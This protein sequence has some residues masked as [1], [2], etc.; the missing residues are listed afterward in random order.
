MALRRWILIATAVVAFGGSYALKRA[1]A[2]RREAPSAPSGGALRIVSL[3][4][5]LTEVAFELGLG[6]RLVGVTSFCVYPPEARTKPQMG[7]YYDPNYEA[8]T[9]ARPD[10]VLTLT[11]HDQVRAELHKLGLATL[12]LDHLTVG[13]ILESFPSIGAACGCPE[14]GAALRRSLESRIRDIRA[15]AAG[16]S[17][18]RVLVSIARMAGD[19][20]MNRITVCGRKGV[21]EELIELAGG[22]NAFDG[23]ID[24]P[25]LSAEGV[26]HADP[27]VIVDLC[28]D[29]KE[30]GLDPD[31]VR[32]QWAAIPG[33]RARVCVVGES[34]AMVPGPRIVLLL[35]D[36]ARALRPEALHD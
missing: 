28:P 32:K 2:D 21:F 9:A 19:A 34:Y 7:G 17:K 36:L 25:A 20:S 29:L 11:E 1:I 8:I 16:R 10:L 6:D 18:P 26:L 15:R 27:D 13:G 3:A 35:E 22:T 31:V 23:E 24:F 5:S 14:R 12:T 33:L 4:P 30:K